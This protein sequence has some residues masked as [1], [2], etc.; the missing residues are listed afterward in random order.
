MEEI[1]LS[2]PKSESKEDTLNVYSYSLARD[3]K[4]ETE[5]DDTDTWNGFTLEQIKHLEDKGFKVKK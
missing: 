2:I 3:Q 5:E 4:E 1:R